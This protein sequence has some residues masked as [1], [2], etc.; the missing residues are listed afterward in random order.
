MIRDRYVFAL[1]HEFSVLE[2]VLIKKK[3]RLNIFILGRTGSLPIL[4][5]FQDN[6]IARIC[7][8]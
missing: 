8:G 3:K 2:M 5:C 1:N 4:F 7:A 6:A